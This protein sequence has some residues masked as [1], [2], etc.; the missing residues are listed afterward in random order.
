VTDRGYFCTG[1]NNNEE[2]WTPPFAFSARLGPKNQEHC[3]VYN[4][5]RLADYLF[6][7]T[8]DVAY[9]D[10]IERNLYNG[11]LAQQHPRT[12]MVTYFLPL[13][14]GARKTWGSPT[15]DFWCCHGTLVQAHTVHNAYVYY[16]DEHGLTV[17]QYIPT[18]GE[19]THDGV[20]V[21]IA[22]RFDSETTDIQD[23]R[24][25]HDGP[26]HRPNRW[27]IDL[28]VTC[29]RPVE[30]T[31]R[32]RL[33][34]WLAGQAQIG[35][36][37]TPEPVPG[38]PSSFHS[39]RRVWH[40]DT[41]RLVFPKALTTSPI[42]DAPDMVAFMDGP[43]VLAGLSDVERV[44]YGDV[45]HPD[46]LLT[47]DDEGGRAQ[48]WKPGYRTRGLDRGFRFVPLYEVTDEAYTV[49]FPVR[50]KP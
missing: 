7:W 26:P 33:P 1:G 11:I 45:A 8:G 42:P 39:I 48:A 46:S 13:H 21:H 47:P 35:V 49:Y 44:L 3:T 32:L 12:G 17:S 9:A 30:F 19:W 20:T 34:W 18:D 16:E 40:T 4:M 50:E 15:Q 27:V 29:A 43:V 2:C 6:R 36:N 10:Y 24:Q 37:G 23:N 41:V 22:Q 28:A 14:A 5:M 25:A 38:G 31:L